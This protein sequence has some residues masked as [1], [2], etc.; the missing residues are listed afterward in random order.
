VAGLIGQVLTQVAAAS[1]NSA[2]RAMMMS[3]ISPRPRSGFAG[4]AG[5]WSRN[6]M[7]QLR[8]QIQRERRSATQR[9]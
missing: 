5:S 3:R 8:F 4:T 2:R 1:A 9:L 6:T 7:A